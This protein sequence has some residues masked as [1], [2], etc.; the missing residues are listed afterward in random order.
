MLT[1]RSETSQNKQNCSKSSGRAPFLSR[2][3][4]PSFQAKDVL[5]SRLFQESRPG[6]HHEKLQFH[7][8]DDSEPKHCGYGQ[9]RGPA[10][11]LPQLFC[12]T[13][14]VPDE[15]GAPRAGL[16]AGSFS[17]SSSGRDFLYP[18]VT[19][20]PQAEAS[21]DTYFDPPGP[22]WCSR[23]TYS[24]L[25]SLLLTGFKWGRPTLTLKRLVQSHA[26]G[27]QPAQAHL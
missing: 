9:L 11:S 25:R 26:A 8:L 20:L 5:I 4:S 2:T 19:S 24:R 23:G 27:S 16:T 6:E 22:P 14:L 3:A 13:S 17:C 7:P 1:A 10:L 18:H 12:V 15:S 21:L